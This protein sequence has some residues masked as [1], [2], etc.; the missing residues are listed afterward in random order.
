[1]VELKQVDIF[2]DDGQQLAFAQLCNALYERELTNLAN[3]PSPNLLPRKLKGLS[4]HIKG[5]AEK[6]L[7]CITPLELDVHNASWQSK[8]ATKCPGNSPDEARNI[9]WFSRYSRMGL[10]VAVYHRDLSLQSLELDSIDRIDLPNMRL[11]TNKFGWFEFDG[12]SEKDAKC[13]LLKP[14]KNTLT[15][16]AC[17]H[18]WNHSGK[19]QP[20]TLTLRELL[21]STQINW[22]SYR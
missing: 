1:M 12:S 4:Y 8:Q 3:S 2:A 5:A 6:L 19:A 11:H 22:R 10:P 17:G 15:A 18:R 20:R 21:L 13:H 16:A 7:T 9:E 14:Q